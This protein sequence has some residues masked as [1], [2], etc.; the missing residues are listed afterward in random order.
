[1]NRQRIPLEPAELDEK[2]M[3]RFW[4]KTVV[5]SRGCI[6]WVGAVRQNGYG[7]AWINRRLM[8]PHRVSAT[9]AH[10]IPLPVD[11]DVDHLCRNRKCVNPQ[12]LEVVTRRENIKRGTSRAAATIQA[13]D[14]EGQ[15]AHG[16]DLTADR[17]W[18]STL[19]G[20]TCRLCRNAREAER[21]KTPEFRRAKNQRRRE[22]RIADPEWAA[23]QRA[24]DKRR[25]PA[26]KTPLAAA[27]GKGHPFDE[28]NTYIHNGR[29]SCKECRRQAVRRRR[30]RVKST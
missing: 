28:D 2:T 21:Q 15:C 29:R 22:R 7:A 17:A 19:E 30:N 12:H 10:G 11:K 18:V 4:A 25:R 5:T 6:E 8:V 3:A 16:H 1:M 24:R 13:F 14:A 9:W 23:E 26:K 20:R 27:C